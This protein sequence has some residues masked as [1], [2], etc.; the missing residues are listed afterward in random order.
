MIMFLKIRVTFDSMATMLWCYNLVSRQGLRG[1]LLFQ[2]GLP[3]RQSRMI[4]PPQHTSQCSLHWRRTASGACSIGVHSEGTSSWGREVWKLL[5]RQHLHLPLRHACPMS[6]Q[7]PRAVPVL[8][9]VTRWVYETSSLSSTSIMGQVS[10][11][12]LQA[13]LAIII[14]LKVK[15]VFVV[16]TFAG[17]CT[18]ST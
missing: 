3:M 16:T 5:W 7:L 17:V 1:K 12:A 4:Q 2:T 18:S 15:T 11:S 10:T 14:S 6:T 9:L 13:G 8:P